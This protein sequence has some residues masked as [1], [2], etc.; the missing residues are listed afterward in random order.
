MSP[1]ILNFFIAAC[2]HLLRPPP[3]S[4]LSLSLETAA[5]RGRYVVPLH[6][7][8][9]PVKSESEEVSFKS[10]YFG[11]VSVGAPD[12]QDF[13]VVFDTGSGHVI[14]PSDD[15]QSV[16]CQ[17]H[18]RYKPQASL[19][20]VDVDYDGTPVKPGVPRD[21]ITVAF[22]TGELTGQ[23]VDDRLCL[24]SRIAAFEPAADASRGAAPEPRQPQPQSGAAAA[25]G[26]ADEAD[27]AREEL[28]RNRKADCVDLRLVMATEMSEEPFHAFA[29]DG[30]M[31]LGLDGLA[32]APEFSFFGVMSNQGQLAQ[33][34]F[35]VFLAE[36]DEE[37]S[38]ISF[39][40]VSPDRLRSAL[41]W[42][43]VESPEMGYWQVRVLRIRVGNQTLDFCSDGTC[44]AV[45]D[46]G[47]SL[48]AVPSDFADELQQAL[49]GPL[50]DPPLPL[51]PGSDGSE[52]IDCKHAQGAALHFDLDDG[53]TVTLSPGDYAR[54][55]VQLS[56]ED[57]DT[58]GGD[59]AAAS[60]GGNS[61]V[62]S[63]GGL[64][65]VG[66][67]EPR[68]RPTLMAIDMP[69]PLGPKLFIWGEPVLRKYYTVYD[70]QAKR[71]GFGI[72]R[73]ASDEDE[74]EE[75]EVPTSR[76]RPLLL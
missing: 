23:F 66:G 45:V 64:G 65:G 58:E 10:V 29:F 39:G 71:V 22:G 35:G 17:I 48:L 21:Q 1:R 38:E 74:D 60:D 47:T 67:G 6:R 72:A 73:H 44:K 52:D 62:E 18:R 7:Q 69:E 31:G 20:A 41:S 68:C 42:T 30:V 49:E 36:S 51:A 43:P 8:R 59:S 9:V 4:C 13:A 14:V 24:G 34:S 12:K 5:G 25:T 27:A 70:W 26:E 75:D 61:W 63:G 46:T 54:P 76:K 57:E 32:L 33:P 40:G 16:S 28:L 37:Q 2:V 11:S 15:C 53:A 50:R 55:T 19:L 3:C 56:A